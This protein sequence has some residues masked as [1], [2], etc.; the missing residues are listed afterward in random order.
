MQLKLW[1]DFI[2][3]WHQVSSFSGEVVRHS[4]GLG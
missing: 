3:K 2:L 1:R 4:S